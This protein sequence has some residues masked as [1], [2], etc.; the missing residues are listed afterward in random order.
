[1]DF[2]C[3]IGNVNKQPNL[4]AKPA[5]SESVEILFLGGLK[6]YK[7]GR[8]VT[9]NPSKFYFWVKELQNRPKNIKQSVE[10]LFLG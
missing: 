9:N 5:Q 4:E 6:N 10:I 2:H 3:G 8:K 7:T 1:M